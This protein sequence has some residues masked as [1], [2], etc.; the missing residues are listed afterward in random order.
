MVSSMT[1]TTDHRMA[2]PEDETTE[3]LDTS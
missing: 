2:H 1:K 3:G